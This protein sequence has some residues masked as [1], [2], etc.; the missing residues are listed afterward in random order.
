MVVDPNRL[1]TSFQQCMGACIKGS[2]LTSATNKFMGHPL[3]RVEHSTL[4]LPKQTR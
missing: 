1:A 4:V 3:L 2:Y